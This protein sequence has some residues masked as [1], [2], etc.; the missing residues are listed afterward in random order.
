M[1]ET[2]TKLYDAAIVAP[3]AIQG[4]RFLDRLKAAHALGVTLIG[5]PC[6]VRTHEGGNAVLFTR[7]Q[8]EGILFPS[9]PVMHERAGEDRFTWTELRPGV[10]VGTYVEGAQS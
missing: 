4:P 1:A 8:H 7:T 3:S 5:N 6:W 10:R 2:E 9:F